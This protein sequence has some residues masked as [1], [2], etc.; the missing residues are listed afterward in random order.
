MTFVLHLAVGR[1]SGHLDF[2]KPFVRR[3]VLLTVVVVS[4]FST[5]DFNQSVPRLKFIL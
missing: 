1:I 5:E 2:E 4:G 3:Q